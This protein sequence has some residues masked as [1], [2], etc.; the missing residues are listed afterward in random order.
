[1][2]S[3]DILTQVNVDVNQEKYITEIGLDDWTPIVPGQGGD[4]DSY[5]TAKAQ[6]LFDL[7][8]SL[9]QLRLARCQVEDGSWHAVLMVDLEGQTWVLDNRHIFPIEKQRLPY[10]WDSYQIAGTEEWEE[11]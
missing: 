5:A 4:C 7:G 6:K 9:E 11:A 10:K 2:N 3:H 1:M 8:W